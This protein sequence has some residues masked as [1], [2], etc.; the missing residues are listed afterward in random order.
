MCCKYCLVAARDQCNGVSFFC[1]YMERMSAATNCSARITRNTWL[2]LCADPLLGT[3]MH[4]SMY[5]CR[6]AVYLIEWYFEKFS[7]VVLNNRGLQSRGMDCL[8]DCGRVVQSKIV[9]R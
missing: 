9:P 2:L 8:V 4:C 6:E 7:R 3:V 1:A 5:E